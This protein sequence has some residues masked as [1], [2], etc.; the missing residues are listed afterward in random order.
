MTFDDHPLRPIHF[1][2]RLQ[3]G[4]DTPTAP[5]V[6]DEDIENETEESAGGGTVLR[7]RACG[8]AITKTGFRAEVDGRHAHVFFNPS[9]ILYE[10]GI[11][12]AAPG[13]ISV[14]PSSLEFTW[15]A[16]HSWRLAA[17]GAC[18]VHLGWIWSGPLGIFYGLILDALIED[19]GGE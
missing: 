2:F 5:P 13:A 9:G 17:C 6:Y 19:S 18:I 11:F 4:A 3:D 15:F 14:G 1:P 16:E 7:C 10:I 12:S 8:H